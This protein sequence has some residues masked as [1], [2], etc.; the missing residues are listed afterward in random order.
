M[1][2]QQQKM[3]L[4]QKRNS[5]NKKKILATGKSFLQQETE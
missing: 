5:Y 2:S 4:Q 1:F 3:F